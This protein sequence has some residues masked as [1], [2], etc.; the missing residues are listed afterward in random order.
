MLTYIAAI[1]DAL[2]DEP[3]W[4][5]WLRRHLAAEQVTLADDELVLHVGEV[6]GRYELLAPAAAA[7]RHRDA[8]W[9]SLEPRP[10]LG[11]VAGFFSW[12]HAADERAAMAHLVPTLI[13]RGRGVIARLDSGRFHETVHPRTFSLANLLE[14]HGF[15][16]GEALLARDGD[17]LDHVVGEVERALAAAGFEAAVGVA[18][19]HHNP[20]RIVGEVRRG[21]VAIA[22][23]L[24][25]LAASAVTLWAYDWDVLDDVAFW[26]D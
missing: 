2:V 4:A 6:V 16:D 24:A 21:G 7:A 3:D 10:W 25:A 5:A 12:T 22:D 15:D 26:I 23:P 14:R 18:S 13:R 19:T 1:H 11:G 17:Y 9:W 8:P 20:I